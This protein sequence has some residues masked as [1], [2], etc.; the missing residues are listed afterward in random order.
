MERPDDLEL[1]RLVLM[2]RRELGEPFDRAWK[3]ALGALG[4]RPSD[5]YLRAERERLLRALDATRIDW[6]LAYDHRPARTPPYRVD[7]RQVARM[8]LLPQVVANPQ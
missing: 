7:P 2:R 4:P 1:V 3:A 8:R 5:A 6:Q